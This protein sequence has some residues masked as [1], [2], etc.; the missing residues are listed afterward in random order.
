MNDSNAGTYCFDPSTPI[1]M[2][3]GSTKEIKNIQLGD[4]TKG[5]EVTGVFQFKAL[6][7]FTI[8]KVL[9]LQVVT[10]LKKMVNLLWL[11]T[12]HYPSRSIRYL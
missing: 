11:K 12:A 1:Q 2:A 6:M 9:L 7:R 4:D 8:T 10:M 5:G 3:D